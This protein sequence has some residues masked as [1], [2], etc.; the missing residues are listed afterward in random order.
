L[1]KPCEIFIEKHFLPSL[2]RNYKTLLLYIVYSC[3]SCRDEETTDNNVIWKSRIC[4]NDLIGD[5]GLGYPIFKNTVVYHSTPLPIN[6]E[7]QSILHGLDTETGKEKWRLTNDDFYPKRN[8][9]LGV[10]DYLYQIDNMVIGCDFSYLEPDAERYV[11]A[12]DIEKGKVLWVS[13]MPH[14]YVRYGTIVRGDEN[15]AYINA[16]SE[17]TFTLLRANIFTG[18]ISAAFNLTKQNL[19]D[20]VQL[21]NTE[22]FNCFYT[23]VYKDKTGDN[24]I[25]CSINNFSDS[26]GIPLTLYIYNL[27]QSIPIYSVFVESSCCNGK[28]EYHNGKIIIGKSNDV[29]CYNAFKDEGVLWQHS[30]I[31]NDGIGFGSGNDQI[32]QVLAYDNMALVFCVD[33]L[34]AFDMNTGNVLYNVLAAGSNT[35]NIIDGVIYQRDRSDLQMRDPRTGKELKRVKTGPTEEAFSSSRPNGADG[36]IFVHTYTDAYCIRAW[37]NN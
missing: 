19:P 4:G 30:V 26:I 22:F 21:L 23:E 13:Q 31:L 16:V 24:I 3:T 17:D 18:E 12:I 37:G 34:V 2:A 5:L 36:K 35:A 29:Y 7:Y 20:K 25:A 33:R 1:I 9:Q 11:Y 8:L 14:G 32:M 10:F 6:N 15:Y 27:T 28:I